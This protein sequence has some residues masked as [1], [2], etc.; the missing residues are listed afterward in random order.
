MTSPPPWM[1]YLHLASAGTATLQ[2]YQKNMKKR[3]EKKRKSIMICWT[4][5]DDNMN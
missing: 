4:K 2:F 5:Y 1:S 3:K